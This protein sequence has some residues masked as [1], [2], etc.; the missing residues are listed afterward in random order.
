[1]SY[2]LI[3]SEAREVPFHEVPLK[4]HMALEDKIVERQKRLL[5]KNNELNLGING[6][7]EGYRQ[8]IRGLIGEKKYRANLEKLQKICQ[9][10]KVDPN[11]PVLNNQSEKAEQERRRLLVREKHNFYH[12]LG[13]DTTG[14]VALRKETVAK[15]KL[16]TG[17]LIDLDLEMAPGPP[18]PEPK[19]TNNPWTWYWPPYTYQWG[20]VPYSG[21]SAG[22][23][24]K[25]ANS[26]ATTG[27]INL[28]SWIQL[29]GA[30]DSDWLKT[31]AMCE[32]GVWFRMPAAGILEVWVWFQDI[33]TDYS[34][35]LSDESGCSDAD[36]HQLSRLYLWTG[37]S[38]ERYVTMVDYTRGESEGSWGNSLTAPGA[39][40][41]R[42]FFSQKAYAADEWVYA[43]IGARDFNYFWVDDMSCRSR[44]YS[45]YFVKQLAIRSTG[46]P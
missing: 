13:F 9:Q 20:S 44:M 25:S 4:D 3:K 10:F 14:A 43:A 5:A 19:P 12:Q 21:G 2:I 16:L 23:V 36:V 32:V 8:A 41:A 28:M 15:A 18:V 33:N 37:G 34:G 35:F 42:Q 11:Q 6:L 7:R 27:E 31:D 17:R 1:M 22:S 29:Y 26:S 30:D 46:A 39:V 40:V 38:T 45:Q 24:W